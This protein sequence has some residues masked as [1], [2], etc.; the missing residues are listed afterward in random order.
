V[1]VCVC[2]KQIIDKTHFIKLINYGGIKVMVFNVY[3][4]IT[5]WRLTKA[6]ILYGARRIL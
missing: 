3:R 4:R 5:K 6:T 2:V 1:K